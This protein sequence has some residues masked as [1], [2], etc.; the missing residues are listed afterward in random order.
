M[1]SVTRI[2]IQQEDNAGLAICSTMVEIDE[3]ESTPFKGLPLHK[4]TLRILL[5]RSTSTTLVFNKRC[6]KTE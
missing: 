5:F 4:D 6:D 1:N 3:E 2:K